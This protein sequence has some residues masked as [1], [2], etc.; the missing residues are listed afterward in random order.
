MKWWTIVFAL[1]QSIVPL[2]HAHAGGSASTGF[3]VHVAPMRVAPSGYVGFVVPQ[4][5]GESA[6]IGVGDAHK[7]K[8]CATCDADWYVAT[9]PALEAKR[10]KFDVRSHTSPGACNAAPS[11]RLPP[12]HAPPTHAV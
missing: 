5:P 6:A 7:R 11:L 4:F 3:H 1:L 8:V 10:S 9:P 12:S 2:L